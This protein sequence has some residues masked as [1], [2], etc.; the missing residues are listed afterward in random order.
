MAV[1]MNQIL[2]NAAKA[3]PPEYALPKDAFRMSYDEDADV[4]YINFKESGEATDSELTDDDIVRR[5]AGDELIGL[6]ILHAGQRI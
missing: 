2:L 4:L 1:S 6:T 5:Y 3:L